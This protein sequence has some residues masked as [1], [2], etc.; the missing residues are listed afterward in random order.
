MSIRTIVMSRNLSAYPN[1]SNGKEVGRLLQI[2]NG[3]RKDE[4]DDKPLMKEIF[5]WRTVDLTDEQVNT[6][7]E[8]LKE[9]IK[10]EEGT[11][12]ASAKKIVINSF[13]PTEIEDLVIRG[14]KPS[15]SKGGNI[16]FNNFIISNL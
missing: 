4:F 12:I 3:D 8:S 2:F 10:N 14:P 15:P 6:I 9:T 11:P 1:K 5:Y 13:T 16:Q 7:N